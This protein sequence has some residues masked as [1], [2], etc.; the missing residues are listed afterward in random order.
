VSKRPGAKP[1]VAE[2]RVAK[3]AEAKRA[4]AMFALLIAS[5]TSIAWASEPPE[6]RLIIRN[7]RFVPAELKVPANTKIKLIVVNQDATPEEFESHELNREKIV[8]GGGTIPV[9]VGPL[10]PG[11]YPFFGDFHSDTAQGALLAQ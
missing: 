7:H 10:K 5:A 11:R 4:V 1:A 9:Y 2:H 8:T 3:R 6:I